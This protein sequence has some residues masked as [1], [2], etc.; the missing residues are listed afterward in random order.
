MFKWYGS[1]VSTL[2]IDFLLLRSSNPIGKFEVIG[3]SSGEHDNTD[4]TR[5]I[6]DAFFPNGASIFVI[7]V[8]DLIKN[9]PLDIL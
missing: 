8:M 6:H 4:V 7:D 5:K 9:D 3:K 2:H 1:E